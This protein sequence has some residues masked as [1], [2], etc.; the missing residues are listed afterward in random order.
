MDVPAKPSVSSAPCSLDVCPSGGPL[1]SLLVSCKGSASAPMARASQPGSRTV[2]GYGAGTI[3]AWRR[4]PSQD[5]TPSG[6][7]SRRE[8]GK[9]G[10]LGWRPGLTP[11]LVALSLVVPSTSWSIRPRLVDTPLNCVA[12]V[13]Q[14]STIKMLH[15]EGQD[16][17]QFSAGRFYTSPENLKSL[18]PAA[19]L[20]AN[21]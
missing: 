17:V 15:L 11:T 12:S 16:S 9:H 3:F 4:R 18:R 2:K 1:S 5:P 10:T 6:T 20:K 21:A 13:V 7:H 19:W 8:S 14:R